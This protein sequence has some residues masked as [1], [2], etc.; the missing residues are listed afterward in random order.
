MRA[1]II[2]LGIVV[3]LL[4]A[5]AGRAYGQG[6]PPL[7]TDDPGTPGDGKWEVNA[8][9]THERAGRERV[10]EA[11]LLDVNCGLGDHI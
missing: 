4:T 5:F 3:L 8:A 9:F 7:I 10:Y 2:R 11:P 6:G 1:M